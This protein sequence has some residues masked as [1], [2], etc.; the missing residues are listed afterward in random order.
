LTGTGGED[1]IKIYSERGEEMKKTLM[2]IV[3]ICMAGL[4][5]CEDEEMINENKELKDE[6]KDLKEQVAL[7]E[8]ENASLKETAEY[9]YRHGVD[10]FNNGNLGDAKK[11]FEKVISQYPDSKLV[12]EAQDMLEI[13]LIKIE[14][15]K[16]ASL[17]PIDTMFVLVDAL[18]VREEPNTESEILTEIYKDDKVEIFEKRGNWVKV[19]TENHTIGWSCVSLSGEIF[20][21]RRSEIK[22]AEK[23]NEELQREEAFNEWKL[24]RNNEDQYIG[25]EVTW[26]VKVRWEAGGYL[27]GCY[28]TRYKCY[29]EGKTNYPV[30]VNT[31]GYSLT[32]D[33][34]V[35]VTGKVEGVTSD[36]DILISSNRDKI[37][38]LGFID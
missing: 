17:K 15:E 33:D 16:V 5:G 11:E 1:N 6:V 38:V 14:E 27:M 13:T 30:L 29:L 34:W 18:R 9:H 35:I 4:I 22:E 21:A 7:L 8:E 37:E 26:R 12:G 23:V 25:T 32:K 36:G 20:L 10:L 24:F 19:R 28:I 3:F 2:T 31:A